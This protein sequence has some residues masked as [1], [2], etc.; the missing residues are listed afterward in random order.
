VTAT[1]DALAALFSGMPYVRTLGAEVAEMARDHV[2]V[3]LPYHD[4]N[5]NRN[6]TLHGG[7]IASLID[8]AGSLAAWTGSSRGA[9]VATS[10]VDLAIHYL[11]AAIRC[12]V[13]AEARV[14]RRGREIV[15]TEVALRSEAEKPIARGLLACRALPPAG[16]AQARSPG[17]D[18]QLRELADARLVSARWSGSPFTAR[19][20]VSSARLD[21]ARVVALLRD[22]PGVADADGRVHEGALAALVDCAGGAAAWSTDGGFDP[23]GRAATIGMH[24]SYDRSTSGE[25]VLALAD[26]PWRSG[27]IFV[28][29]VTLCGRSS[30]RSLGSASV[31]YRIVRSA[32]AG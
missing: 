6:G 22:Q 30:G 31:T 13:F 15:F 16:E 4:E 3:A 25:D 7:V 12:A 2:R 23:R 28:V 8:L 26:A 5:A 27:E 11:A 14:L 10:T 21:D 18:P 19:L 32:R 24:L 17:L 20:G 1:L 29:P 9:H